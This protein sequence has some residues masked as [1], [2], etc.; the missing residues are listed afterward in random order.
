MTDSARTVPLVVAALAE[1]QLALR[2]LT[3]T[4]PTLDEVF[5]HHTGRSTGTGTDPMEPK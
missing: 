4:P 3:V 1:R 2:A 5:F